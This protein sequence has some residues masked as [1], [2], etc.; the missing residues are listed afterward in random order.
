[1]N[2]SIVILLTLIL[3]ILLLQGCVINEDLILEGNNLEEL[4]L[5]IDIDKLREFK[6]PNWSFEIILS[7]TV[8][9]KGEKNDILTIDGDMSQFGN[10]SVIGMSFSDNGIDYNFMPMRYLKGFRKPKV[11]RGKEVIEINSKKYNLNKIADYKIYEDEEIVVL[12]ITDIVSVESFDE[13]LDKIMHPE[14]KYNY[15]WI[16]EAYEYLISTEELVVKKIR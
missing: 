8:L 2:K 6:D 14:F 5:I 13:R 12:D 15:E 16:K 10:S 4:G 7:W 9:H 1:M 3:L 11:L